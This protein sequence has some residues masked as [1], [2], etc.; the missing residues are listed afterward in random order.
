[1]Q[2]LPALLPLQ[3]IYAGSCELFGDTELPVC[4]E[5]L[6]AQESW[7]R[8]D[9]WHKKEL[10]ING[11]S[12]LTWGGN[13]NLEGRAGIWAMACPVTPCPSIQRLLVLLR[14]TLFCWR[15]LTCF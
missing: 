3:L 10:A 8:S 9:R 7:R 4:I 11:E 1:M 14:R 15:W 12:L 2:S 13:A 5:M 6:Q